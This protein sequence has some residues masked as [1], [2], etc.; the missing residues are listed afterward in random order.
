MNRCRSALVA[1]L[2]AVDSAQYPSS[3]DA[4]A[5]GTIF[6]QAATMQS[7]ALML[8]CPPFK[9]DQKMGYKYCRIASDKAYGQISGLALSPAE[10]E[11]VHTKSAA[12]GLEKAMKTCMASASTPAKKHTCRTTTAMAALKNAL[13]KTNVTEAELESFKKKAAQDAV[14]HAMETCMA[15]VASRSQAANVKK[16]MMG[17]CKEDSAKAALA[18]QL[19][20]RFV[21]IYCIINCF[22]IAANRD[23]SMTPS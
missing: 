18:T 23:K 19:G 14:M 3:M 15:N 6:D 2:K 22:Q 17:D 8:Q 11:E 12:R 5:F 13:G 21:L 4:A 9:G 16:A 1:K 7:A 10:K 20:G